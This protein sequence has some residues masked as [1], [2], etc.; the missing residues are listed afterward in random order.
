MT[1]DRCNAVW[2][3]VRSGGPT[4]A[5]GLPLP[6][7]AP[8]GVQMLRVSC[9]AAGISEG[10]LEA[11]CRQMAQLLGD[12][13]QPSGGM[14]GQ[15]EAGLRRRFLRDLPGPA[16]EAQFVEAC[17]RLAERSN[18]GWSSYSRPSGVKWKSRSPGHARARSST[19]FIRCP[20][21][22]RTAS[23]NWW[24]SATRPMRAP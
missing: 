11:A 14:P 20:P 12:E 1:N 10:P 18:G 4:V 19:H 22:R 24:T 7:S 2:E 15:L 9:D 21:T 13:R 23:R 5:I 17:N 16:L 6:P 3:R 8:S